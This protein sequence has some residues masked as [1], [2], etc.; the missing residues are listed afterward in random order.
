MN[1]AILIVN[2]IGSG[3]IIC[4]SSLRLSH[5]AHRAHPLPRVTACLLL[6]A[7]RFR[8]RH[9]QVRDAWPTMADYITQ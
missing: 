6:Q 5:R 1:V 8:L 9:K 3:E 4:Y 2:R 7:V